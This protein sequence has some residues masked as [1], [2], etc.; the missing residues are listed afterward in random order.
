MKFSVGKEVKR[1]SEITVSTEL[2]QVL[3]KKLRDQVEAAGLFAPTYIRYRAYC[4]L[5]LSLLAACAVAL[6]VAPFWWERVILLP[7]LTTFVVVQL[8]YM[9]H[10]SGH[11]E[12]FPGDE[13][14]NVQFLLML[15]CLV[16][17]SGDWWTA[18]HNA[19]HTHPNH[20]IEDPNLRV[21][22]LSFSKLQ[23]LSKGPIG[24]FF[25]RYQ[26][27]YYPVIVGFETI[28][29]R[30]DSFQHIFGRKHKL[31]Y[32]ELFGMGVYFA[33]NIAF[34]WLV[35]GWEA[36]PFS[37]LHQLSL[38]F[39]LGV[40]FAPNHKGMRVIHKGEQVS[41]LEEQLTTT[42]NVRPG[43]LIDFLTG[44]LNYQVEHHLFPEI[45]RFRLGQVRKIVKPFCEQHNL[46]YFETSL[47]ES[48][49]RMF[50]AF[51]ESG[52]GKEDTEPYIW[53][54]VAA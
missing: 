24:R 50:R 43:W 46:Y 49:K 51:T 41:F 21:G 23:W 36:I 26:A 34:L 39:Y 6:I 20:E 47:W 4:T 5:A 42:R 1:L 15:T 19:H 27:W 40:V 13:R 8:E 12:V 25:V 32:M 53:D 29:M 45:P 38:G 11:R 3:Y 37:V 7:I 9:A 17:I 44:G 18:A 22:I 48:Y 14:S 30:V 28:M 52:R 54:P 10:D 31:W 2:D 35:L 33:T 16:G